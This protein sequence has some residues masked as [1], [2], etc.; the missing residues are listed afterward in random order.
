MVKSSHY[1][2]D[3]NL[4]TAYGDE[5]NADGSDENDEFLGKAD[6]T[7]PSPRCFGQLVTFVVSGVKFPGR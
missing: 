3:L 1:V 6:I 2:S 4:C 7:A 5:G